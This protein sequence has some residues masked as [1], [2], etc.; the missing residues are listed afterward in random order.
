MRIRSRIERLEDELLPLPAGDTL[1]W[2]INWVDEERKVVST[3][4]FEVL[5]PPPSNRRGRRYRGLAA[6]RDW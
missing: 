2:H 5:L 3:R 4:V 6:R 1:R